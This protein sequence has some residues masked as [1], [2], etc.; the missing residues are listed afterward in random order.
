MIPPWNELLTPFKRCR[1]SL[2]VI[3]QRALVG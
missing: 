3:F 1:E 2:L